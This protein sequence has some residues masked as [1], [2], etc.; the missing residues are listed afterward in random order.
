MPKQIKISS[1]KLIAS[2]NSIKNLPKE[3]KREWKKLIPFLE[4]KDKNL[5]FQYFYP[6]SDKELNYELKIIAKNNLK[7]KL[8]KNINKLFSEFKKTAAKKEKTYKKISK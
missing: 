1:T 6:I 8:G 2:I 4:Q 3:E 5:L 7:N